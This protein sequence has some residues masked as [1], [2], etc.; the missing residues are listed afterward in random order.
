MNKTIA[1]ITL[2]TLV[3][4][5]AFWTPAP[6]TAQGQIGGATHLAGTWYSQFT[7]G[8]GLA[9][10]AMTQYDRSGGVI[11][12]DTTDFGGGGTTAGLDSTQMGAWEKTGAQS[13]TSKSMYFSYDLAGNH[14]YTVV[15]TNSFGFS[16]SYTPGDP[17]DFSYVADLY[18]A[19]QNPITDAPLVP[20]IDG[21]SG[22]TWRVMAD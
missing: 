3:S 11:T 8:A 20:G 12:L 15:V 4:A 5:F 2:T 14:L 10:Q 16:P 22:Q 13:Y 21:G 17:G 7:T 6:A 19:S 18:L 9:G 1:A